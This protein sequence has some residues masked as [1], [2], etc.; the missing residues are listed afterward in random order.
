VTDDDFL[1]IDLGDLRVHEIETIE[2]VIGGPID[3]AFADGAPRGKVLRA[4]GFVVKRRDNPEFTLEDAGNLRIRL[5]D[6]V[7]PTEAAG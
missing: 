3:K 6:D 1:S 5:A 7:D 4:I 2:E